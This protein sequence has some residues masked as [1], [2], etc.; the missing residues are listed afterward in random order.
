MA[1]TS[2]MPL[3][4]RLES[5]TRQRILLL[6]EKRKETGRI[7]LQRTCPFGLLHCFKRWWTK[8]FYKFDFAP[9]RVFDKRKFQIFRGTHCQKTRQFDDVRWEILSFLY[10]KFGR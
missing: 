6:P 10:M 7:L 5:E 3:R 4:K 9:R 8:T 1:D 2:S